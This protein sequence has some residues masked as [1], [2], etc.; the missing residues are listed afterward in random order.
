MKSI[1]APTQNEEQEVFLENANV[2]VKKM[3]FRLYA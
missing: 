3:F 2:A 1:H